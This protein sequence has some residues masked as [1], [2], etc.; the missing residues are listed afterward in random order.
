MDRWQKVISLFN[1]IIELILFTGVYTFISTTLA[2]YVLL[3]Y[4]NL[5]ENCSSLYS[6]GCQCRSVF[7]CSEVFEIVV[8]FKSQERIQHISTI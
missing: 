4:F 5:P 3:A 1:D 2:L 7:E 8:G 6:H